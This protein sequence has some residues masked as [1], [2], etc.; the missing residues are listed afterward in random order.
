MHRRADTLGLLFG[1]VGDADGFR[2]YHQM[3]FPFRLLSPVPDKLKAEDTL[4]IRLAGADAPE[5]GHFGNEAQPFA[6]EAKEELK[7]LVE[8]RTVWCEVSWVRRARA[9]S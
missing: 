4:S 5:S 7:R 8:N 3:P 2:L 9:G 6:K 1:R